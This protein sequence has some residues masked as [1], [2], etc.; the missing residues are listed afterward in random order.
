M[1]DEE[2]GLACPA[3]GTGGI[4]CQPGP[5]G[6]EAQLSVGRCRLT[7]EAHWQTPW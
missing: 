5:V 4:G 1:L 6:T 2:R 7:G 3:E